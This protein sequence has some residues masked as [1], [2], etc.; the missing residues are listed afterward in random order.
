M[1]TIKLI[2]TF[3]ISLSISIFITIFCLFPS[4]L[5]SKIE[6]VY[7]K[8]SDVLDRIEQ[9]T[10]SFRNESSDKS[11]L[12]NHIMDLKDLLNRERN[13]YNVSSD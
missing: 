2:S 1:L 7:V 12:H 5:L 6:T 13:D 8:I 11:E 10:T 4:Q 9:K 3:G